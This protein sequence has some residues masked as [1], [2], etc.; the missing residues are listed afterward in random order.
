MSQ[1]EY[2]SRPC[3]L[4]TDGSHTS[5]FMSASLHSP[6]HC[7]GVHTRGLDCWRGQSRGQQKSHPQHWYVSVVYSVILFLERRNRFGINNS[8]RKENK[9]FVNCNKLSNKFHLSTTSYSRQNIWFIFNVL[10]ESS[11]Q[12]IQNRRLRLYKGMCPL[13]SICS[14]SV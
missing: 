6:C 1:E 8:T 5:I 11:P 2:L 7:Q 14:H 10:G 4:F 12:L 9:T 13:Y 3:V